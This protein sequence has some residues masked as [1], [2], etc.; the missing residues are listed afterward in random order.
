M[1]NIMSQ[2]HLFETPIIALK[3]NIANISIEGFK[4]YTNKSSDRLLVILGKPS[5][6]SRARWLTKIICAP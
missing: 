3:L 2:K 4:A 6:I 5:S 1:F